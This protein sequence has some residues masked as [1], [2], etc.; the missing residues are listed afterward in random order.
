MRVRGLVPSELVEAAL[1]RYVSLG[2]TIVPI[3]PADS[4]PDGKKPRPYV[5]WRGFQKVA[6]TAAQIMTWHARWPTAGWAARASSSR[7]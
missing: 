5:E 1:E 3:R 4:A 7:A 6:P 2:W